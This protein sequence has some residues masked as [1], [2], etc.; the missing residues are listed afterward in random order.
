VQ[1]GSDGP[2]TLAGGTNLLFDTTGTITG[3]GNVTATGLVGSLV[4]VAASSG[5]GN[6]VT[7][8]EIDPSTTT[9]SLGDQTD[10]K[11]LGH[12][13]QGFGNGEGQNG[14]IG[15]DTDTSSVCH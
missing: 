11:H 2:F 12:N 4:T 6:V 1:I 7:A 13:G 14:I 10:K 5:G 9:T 8:G 3:L 15:T